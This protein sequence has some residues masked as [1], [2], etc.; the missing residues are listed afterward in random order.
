MELVVLLI[1]AFIMFVITYFAGKKVGFE[2]GLYMA[3]DIERESEFNKRVRKRKIIEDITKEI[4]ATMPNISMNQ[5]R[6]IEKILED[7][8]DF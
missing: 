4:W 5:H 8:I 6:R 1:G 3:E 7:K 2:E